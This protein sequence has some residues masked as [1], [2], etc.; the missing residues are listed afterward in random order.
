MHRRTMFRSVLLLSLVLS[1]AEFAYTPET[2]YAAGAGVDPDCANKIITIDGSIGDWTCTP[3]TNSVAG[4]PLITESRYVGGGSS[5]DSDWINETSAF[6][7]DDGSATQFLPSQKTA[8]IKR[9]HVTW[10]SIYLYMA[11]VGPNQAWS[12]N[13][14]MDIFIAIDTDTITGT[15]VVLPSDWSINSGIKQNRVMSSPADKRVD[16][17]GW[18]PDI[19]INIFRDQGNPIG[20]GAYADIRTKDSPDNPTYPMTWGTDWSASYA[21]NDGGGGIHEVRISWT[22]L[23]VA[24]P[25]QNVGLTMNFAV[26]TTYN[27]EGYDAYDSA[28]GVG[29]GT[30][31]ESIGDNPGDSD[32][33][34]TND[35]VTGVLDGNC[36][37]GNNDLGAGTIRQPSSDNA[38]ADIDTIETYFTITNVGMTNPTAINNSLSANRDGA[39]VLVRWNS[40]DADATTFKLERADGNNW[41]ELATLPFSPLGAYSYRDQTVSIEAQ[42]YRVMV[43]R[44]DGSSYLLSEVEVSGLSQ[45][46][47][48]LMLR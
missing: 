31:N 20:L 12:D 18:Q 42:R 44:S 39:D 27:P 45:V 26:Y 19:F 24:Q 28:P 6:R 41:L 46:F 14:L 29:N 15:S 36:G 30:S 2:V 33:C 9:F 22:R 48:P 8:D 37:A 3:D 10:D 47:V 23:G 40:G 34:V 32:R 16:F 25:N 13:D 1:F 7:W 35:P 21:D 17:A 5:T 38:Q 4:S 11:V 43:T